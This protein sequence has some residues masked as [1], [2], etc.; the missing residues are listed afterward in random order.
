[1]PTA[2]SVAAGTVPVEFPLKIF[3]KKVPAAL[4][5]LART[6]GVSS[7]VAGDSG[8]G[9]LTAVGVGGAASVDPATFGAGTDAVATAGCVGAASAGSVFAAAVQGNGGSTGG[10]M[11][12]AA[13]CHDTGSAGGAGAASTVAMVARSTA[14]TVATGSAIVSGTVGALG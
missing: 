14:D 13:V 1:M 10:V 12:A 8:I 7:A 9:A 5:A 3:P 11:S 4:V 2:G 6:V